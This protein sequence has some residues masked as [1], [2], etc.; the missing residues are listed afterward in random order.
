MVFIVNLSLIDP[1][2]DSSSYDSENK[3][4]QHEF[5]NPDYDINYPE[6]I[7]AAVVWFN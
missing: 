7:P 2:L 1:S 6:I 5:L 4:K 3:D